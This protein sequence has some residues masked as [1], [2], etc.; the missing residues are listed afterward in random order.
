MRIKITYFVCRYTIPLQYLHGIKILNFRGS[1]KQIGKV[2]FPYAP[3]V[4]GIN[5][6]L[7][8]LLSPFTGMVNVL[9]ALIAYRT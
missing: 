6:Y 7:K 4:A 9:T 2:H 5:P 1:F 8:I 3:P